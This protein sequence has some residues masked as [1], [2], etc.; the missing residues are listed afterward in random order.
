MMSL[1][2]VL[3]VLSLAAPS[4]S[5]AQPAP[6]SPFDVRL[7]VRITPDTVTVGQRFIVV[8]R[9]GAPRGSIVRFPEELDSTARSS[10][11][12]PQLIG[13]PLVDSAVTGG[14]LIHS[15]AY[16]FTAWDVGPQPLGLPAIAVDYNGRIGYVSLAT[17]QVF[18]RS[19]LPADT[20]L[21]KPKPARLPM[22]LPTIDW[23][24]LIALLI[25]LGIAALLWWAWRA[26][27]RRRNRPLPPF[28][29]AEREFARIEAMGLI[30]AGDPDRYLALMTDVMRKYLAARVEG[31]LG[32][33]TTAELLRGAA[34]IHHAAPGLGDLLGRADLVKFAR[35]HVT[36]AEAA[37]LGARARSIV[38]S[39]EDHFVASDSDATEKRAAA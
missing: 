37:E 20:L 8:V 11:L 9:V 34:P 12:A 33:N 30:A 27:R 24:P 28:E 19:V 16:R 18:V 35:G 10:A 6:R 1:R 4:A 38:R 25:A 2:R 39:V 17:Q 26:W 15:A 14:S 13:R 3:V 32:S 21:R 23:R 31:I 22:Q 36:G 29:A 7:G 5:M